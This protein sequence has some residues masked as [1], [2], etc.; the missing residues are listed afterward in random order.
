M[1]SRGNEFVFPII[2]VALQVNPYMFSSP[3]EF[4]LVK[5][6]LILGVN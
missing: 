5:E 4:M 2:A 6:I 1:F 3:P